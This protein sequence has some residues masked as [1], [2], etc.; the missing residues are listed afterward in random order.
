MIYYKA[1]HDI[2]FADFRQH[3]RPGFLTTNLSVAFSYLA[4]SM[5]CADKEAYLLR[6]DVSQAVIERLTK[7]IG[8]D[9][10]FLKNK[11]SY[12]V[13]CYSTVG[14]SAYRHGG[15]DTIVL[16]IPVDGKWE[17]VSRYDNR[18]AISRDHDLVLG[19]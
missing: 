14:S 13:G 1:M 6:I 18:A 15:V 12:P 9:L 17:I 2:G 3:H 16:N 5:D 7:L 10:C 11:R 8:V 4:C 19:R